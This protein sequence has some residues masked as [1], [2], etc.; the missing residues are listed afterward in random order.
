MVL[1][2]MVMRFCGS[3]LRSMASS[4]CIPSHWIGGPAELVLLLLLDDARRP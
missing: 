4:R 1:V 2:R 3:G